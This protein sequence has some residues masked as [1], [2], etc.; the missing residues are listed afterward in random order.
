MFQEA[1]IAEERAAAKAAPLRAAINPLEAEMVKL[2]KEMAE[3]RQLL[4]Q[5]VIS[6]AEFEQAN[7]I[8]AKRLSDVDMNLRRWRQSVEQAQGYTFKAVII[9]IATGLVG[10]VS[11]GIKTALGK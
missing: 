9:V 2:G 6:V 3:Y 10:M 7:V 1:A 11:L 8:A 4:D 5:G